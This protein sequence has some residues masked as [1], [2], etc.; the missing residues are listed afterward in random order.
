M[1]LIHIFLRRKPASLESKNVPIEK[2]GSGQRSMFEKRDANPEREPD[3]IN[4]DAEE[5]DQF[6]DGSSG[7]HST[8]RPN[9]PFDKTDNNQDIFKTLEDKA[10]SS[11][12]KT[13]GR[14][15]SLFTG[16]SFSVPTA[17]H[18]TTTPYGDFAAD[19]AQQGQV[20]SE[21]DINYFL[22]DDNTFDAFDND[23]DLDEIIEAF[24]PNV[25]V[26]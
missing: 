14:P 13:I 26:R 4:F 18:E 23:D 1:L 5:R 2:L 22:N 15:Q 20:L 17:Y 21:N 7:S 12:K 19:R 10:R 16:S 25:K 11:Q 3:L 24:N 9:Y 6:E 8:Y